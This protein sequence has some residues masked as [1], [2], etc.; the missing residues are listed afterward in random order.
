[1]PVSPRGDNF[2]YF[3]FASLDNEILPKWGLLLREKIAYRGANSFIGGFAL[4]EKG[5]RNENGR[6]ASPKIVAIPLNGTQN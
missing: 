2:S 5:G 3:V 1:M 6:V 4:I